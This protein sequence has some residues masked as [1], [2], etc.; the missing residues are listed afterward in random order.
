METWRDVHWLVT[1]VLTNGPSSWLG[2][3]EQSLW[4]SHIY[5]NKPLQTG[6]AYPH[7]HAQIFHEVSLLVTAPH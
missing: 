4:N 1:N 7:S 5:L 2:A 3:F 6:S